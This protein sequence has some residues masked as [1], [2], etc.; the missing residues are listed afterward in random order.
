MGT[1]R[2]FTKTNITRPRK[3]G[4]AK[5]NRQNTQRKRL[6][7]L[8]VSEEEVAKLNPREIRT[9]LARPAKITAAK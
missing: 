9:M 5:V 4:A 2:K 7:A 3:G 6:I 1:G 8:G